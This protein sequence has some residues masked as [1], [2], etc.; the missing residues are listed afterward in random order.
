MVVIIFDLLIQGLRGWATPWDEVSAIAPRVT[1]AARVHAP[2]NEKS[3]LHHVLD[4]SHGQ[5]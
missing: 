3:R 4:Q 1:F 5:R 2:I